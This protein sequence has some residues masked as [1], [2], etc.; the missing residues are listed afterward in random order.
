[1]EGIGGL[2]LENEEDEDV[3]N[4][5]VLPSPLLIP[6]FQGLEGV[7]KFSGTSPDLGDFT[8]RVQDGMLALS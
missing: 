8:I 2:D 5:L 4:S 7:V 6:T 1:M 3:S